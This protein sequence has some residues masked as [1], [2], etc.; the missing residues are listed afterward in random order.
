M[1]SS[2]V[3]D[4][5]MLY[6]IMA[7][8]EAFRHNGFFENVLRNH[9]CFFDLNVF[10]ERCNDVLELVNEFISKIIS[11]LKFFNFFIFIYIRFKQ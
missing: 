4:N 6:E 2:E 1:Y 5:C 7:N 9:N 11:S 10:M 3:V 8:L